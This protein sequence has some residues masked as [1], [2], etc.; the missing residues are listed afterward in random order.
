MGRRG[1]FRNQRIDDKICLD[2][3]QIMEVLHRRGS[4]NAFIEELLDQKVAAL[5]KELNI[6]SKPS[7]HSKKVHRIG[8]AKGVI[9]SDER[10]RK[11]S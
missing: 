9:E 2:L 10:N 7:A 5:K 4:L 1:A 11:A 3:E 8:P 6:E